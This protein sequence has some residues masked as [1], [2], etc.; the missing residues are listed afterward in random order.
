MK[1]DSLCACALSN[2]GGK[3]SSENFGFT[4]A[5]EVE[6]SLVDGVDF[7]MGH[8]LA[9]ERHHA[10]RHVAVEPIVRRAHVEQSVLDELL[11]LEVGHTH[12]DAHL[13]GFI[14]AR[15]DATI[16]VGENNDSLAFELGLKNALAAD[17]EVVAVNDAYHGE[18]ICKVWGKVKVF[19]RQF[20][21]RAC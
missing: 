15:H 16:V 9:H 5:F 2:Q 11:H 3:L 21:A 6:E 12:F 1:A 13:L 7:E 18:G 19:C 4:D 17:E 14:A 20:G 8:V 10:A